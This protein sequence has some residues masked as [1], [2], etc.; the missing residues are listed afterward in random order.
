M[1]G[2]IALKLSAV[3][4]VIIIGELWLAFFSARALLFFFRRKALAVASARDFDEGSRSLDLDARGRAPQQ[5]VY[6]KGS[7]SLVRIA[8]IQIISRRR[9]RLSLGETGSRVEIPC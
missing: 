3:I 7:Q 2:R 6:Y 9:V 1:L 5:G 4:A 8:F